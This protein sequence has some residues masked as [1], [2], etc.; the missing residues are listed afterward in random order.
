[1]KHDLIYGVRIGP[2]EIKPLSKLAIHPLNVKRTEPD[3]DAWMVF[4]QDIK[5]NGIRV[6]LLI[7]ADGKIVQGQRRFTAAKKMGLAEAPVRYLEPNPEHV[8][9]LKIIYR[10]NGDTRRNYTDFELEEIVL[11]NWEKERILMVLP[12][13]VT[14]SQK[15]EKPLEEL[16]PEIAAISRTRAK[17]I[18]ADL[19]RRLK[20]EAAR[21]RLPDLED[22]EKRFGINRTKEW[23]KF[24]KQIE[25]AEKKISA[26]NEKEVKP[27]KE[28]Q[29]E[30]EKELRQLGGLDRFKKLL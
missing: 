15:Q 25:S 7:T 22:G 17:K 10:D 9:L 18:L 29:K 23:I 14:R 5:Q 16:L 2:V 28:K 11:A 20:E 21:K 12:R 26:I 19:R 4:C 27:L 8:T 13:G 30:I 3:P 24:E 1:M 6:P